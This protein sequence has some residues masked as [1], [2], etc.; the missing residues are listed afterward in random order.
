MHRSQH[1]RNTS[2]RCSASL[3]A[4]TP[5][6]NK[7]THVSVTRP[8]RFKTKPWRNMHSCTRSSFKRRAR[9][10]TIGSP[11][12]GQC[13]TTYRKSAGSSRPMRRTS[14][15]TSSPQSSRT[16]S[17]TRPTT[18]K[19]SPSSQASKDMSDSLPPRR[20]MVLVRTSRIKT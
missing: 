11:S 5:K 7:S 16:R 12:W 17:A 18:T 15:R 14:T 8:K 10:E 3:H 2:L 1:I 20:F 4:E 13:G 6:Y 9:H 19:R